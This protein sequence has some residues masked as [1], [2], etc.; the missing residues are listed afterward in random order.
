M[1]T[2]T[3][4]TATHNAASIL[5]N[6]QHRKGQAKAVSR[7]ASDEKRKTKAIKTHRAKAINPSFQ[8][9]A[10]IMPKKVATPLPPWN[11]N[12]TGNKWPRKAKKPAIKA[13]SKLQ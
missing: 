5:T 12:H 8:L 4:I 13:S 6:H 11:F 10:N 9:I 7:E 3:V 2:S 1:N